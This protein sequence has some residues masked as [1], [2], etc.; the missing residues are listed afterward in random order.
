MVW[1]PKGYF[2]SPYTEHV[3]L[4]ARDSVA[5]HQPPL[6]LFNTELGGERFAVRS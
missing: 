5:L 4:G 1:G 3:S 6:Q 2:L